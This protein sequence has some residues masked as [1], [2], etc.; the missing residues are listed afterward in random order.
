MS[1]EAPGWIHIEFAR[2]S[3]KYQSHVTST[4]PGWIH[5]KLDHCSIKS[6]SNNELSADYQYIEKLE[7]L[8]KIDETLV[9]GGRSKFLH[10]YIYM[11]IYIYMAASHL[12]G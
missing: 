12:R 3:I 11:Y 7:K 1:S 4:A 10:I 6:P 2:C 9:I 8:T 5:I